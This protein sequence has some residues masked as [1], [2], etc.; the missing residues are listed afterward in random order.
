M[1]ARDV[2]VMLKEAFKDWNEDNAPRLGA[3]LRRAAA[4]YYRGPGAPQVRD[5]TMGRRWDEEERWRRATS[6]KC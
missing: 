4:R 5:A 1:G 6:S 3:A 2:W